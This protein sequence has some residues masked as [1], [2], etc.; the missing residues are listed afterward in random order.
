ML[1]K[2]TLIEKIVTIIQDWGTF[3]M[4]ELE[5]GASLVLLKTNKL[6]YTLLDEFTLTGAKATRY[7]NGCP[8]TQGFISYE[9]ISSELLEEIL[10]MGE[11]FVSVNDVVN[12]TI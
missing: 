3:T 6:T 2:K 5:T 11:L 7:V 10:M 4:A 1:D 12:N 9:K 8:K